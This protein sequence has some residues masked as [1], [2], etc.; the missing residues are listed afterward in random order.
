MKSILLVDDETIICAELQ[1]TLRRFR[2]HVEA[3]HTLEAALRSIRRTTF[4]AILL[5]F[6]LKS[7]RSTNA[8]A[9]NGLQLLRQLH[10]SHITV[11]VLMFTA[12]EGE[13]YKA[14]SLDAGADDFVPKTSGILSLVSRLRAHLHKR[15]RKSGKGPAEIRSRKVRG[16]RKAEYVHRDAKAT[17]EARLPKKS[18]CHNANG[19]CIFKQSSRYITSKCSC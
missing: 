3:A 14:A 5:E 4:D 17:P 16:L 1:R 19:D 7:E 13:P 9:G 15:E 6:N 12:I 8:R 18:E 2:F 11:P 10:A